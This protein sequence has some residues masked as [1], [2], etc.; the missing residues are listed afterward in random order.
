M[1]RYDYYGGDLMPQVIHIFGAS[2]SGTTTLG[3]AL[4][5]A[6]GYFHMDTDDYFWLPTDPKFTQKRPRDERISL[7][8]EDI[9][10]NNNIVLSGALCDWGDVLI[11][12]FTLA[13]RLETDAA[14]RLKRLSA[15]E[16]TR[17][18]SR[19]EPGGDMYRQHQDFL[20]W[21]KQYDTGGPE[22]RSRSKLDLWQKQVTCP[23]ITLD[24]G[25]D[26]QENVRIILEKA[27]N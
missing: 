11:P 27:K 17:F 15:R 10:R 6:L 23:L 24:G 5:R 9:S 18:G 4:C 25:R 1:V 8:E 26:V 20:A 3:V 19:I 12:K 2:G 7:M 22:M 21:A 16:H 13:V 14:L